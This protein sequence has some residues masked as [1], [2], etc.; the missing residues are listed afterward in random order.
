MTLPRWHEEA[1]DK[2]HDRKA[3]DCGDA[4]LNEFLQK[5]ARQAHEGGGAKTFCAIDDD[6]Q[7]RVLGFY[8]LAPS[9]IAFD[10]RPGSSPRAFLVMTWGDFSWR[11][12]PHIRRCKDEGSGVSFS[13]RRASGACAWRPRLAAS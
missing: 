6:M 5:H 12:S 13:W 1:I 11:A 9:S 4:A 2:A 3:F 8:S 10:R 7:G